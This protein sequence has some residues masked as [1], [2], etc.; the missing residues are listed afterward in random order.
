MHAAV[1]GHCRV[2][3]EQAQM[4]SPNEALQRIELSL[5][6][7]HACALLGTNLQEGEAEFAPIEGWPNATYKQE[8]AAMSAAYEALAKRICRRLP[9]DIVREHALQSATAPLPANARAV[10]EKYANNAI[11][12]L[13]QIYGLIEEGKYD[14]AQDFC[15]G[16]AEWYTQDLAETASLPADAVRPATARSDEIAAEV[17]RA[18]AKFPT[19]PTDPLHAL[20]VLGEEFGELTKAMVQL[21]YEPHKTSAE[22]VKIEAI[23]T[24]AMALRLH[25]SLDQYEYRPG[26]QHKQNAPLSETPAGGTAKVPERETRRV[27]KADAEEYRSY[28]T[29]RFEKANS[30][31]R[32]RWLDR[33]WRYEHSDFDE[34]GDFD[35]LLAAAPSPDGN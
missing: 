6:G 25:R 8:H 1:Q 31:Y 22:E 5:D 30:G 33:E 21:T 10:A 23:Q 34:R 12:D 16:A 2:Q 3:E 7:S 15:R 19:W 13:G 24:V 28:I 32:F 26:A 11:S 9:F 29:A 14:E 27:Y 18:V 4:T 17:E 35:L 20:A